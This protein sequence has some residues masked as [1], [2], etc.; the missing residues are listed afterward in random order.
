[1]GHSRGRL[2]SRVEQTTGFRQ[3]INTK[4]LVARNHFQPRTMDTN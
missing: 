2:Q 3:Q 4:D 1:M